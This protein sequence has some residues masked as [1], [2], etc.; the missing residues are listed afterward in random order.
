MGCAGH[1]E[2]CPAVIVFLHSKKQTSSCLP[3]CLP[4]SGKK[5]KRKKKAVQFLRVFTDTLLLLAWAQ[6]L[7][8]CFFS[9]RRFSYMME[10]DFT[11]KR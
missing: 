8:S 2:M 7:L 3:C 10:G 11:V 6:L 4:I 9:M 1:L 5:K